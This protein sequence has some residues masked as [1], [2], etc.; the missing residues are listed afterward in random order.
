MQTVARHDVKSDAD[1]Q[2]SCQHDGTGI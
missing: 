1:Q 2:I